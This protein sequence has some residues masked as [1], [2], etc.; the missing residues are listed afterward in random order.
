MIGGPLLLDDG[1]YSHLT[2]GPIYEADKVFAELFHP[3]GYLGL[4]PHC[5]H[6]LD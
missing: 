4:D 6:L 5:Y 1:F 3:V 2:E